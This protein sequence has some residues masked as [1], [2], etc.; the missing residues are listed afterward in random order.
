MTEWNAWVAES[1]TERE[2]PRKTPGSKKAFTQA[3]NK[4]C[5]NA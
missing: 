2:M 4:V 1:P 3:R 5:A